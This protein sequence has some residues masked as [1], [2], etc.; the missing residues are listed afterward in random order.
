VSSPTGLL[1]DYT[2][3]GL[4]WDP[5]KSTYFYSVTF[6]ATSGDAT[7]LNANPTFPAYHRKDPVDWL[8]FLGEW[9][10]DQLPASDPR[11]KEFVGFFKVCAA[12][13]RSCLVAPILSGTVEE[14]QML[15]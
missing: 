1:I 15:T 12:P 7:A 10:D 3:K 14:R 8:Y 4:L 11:Q 2:S 13:A 9:G 6:P 5:T